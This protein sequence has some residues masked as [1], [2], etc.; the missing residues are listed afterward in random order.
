MVNE[1]DFAED[2][3]YEILTDLKDRRGFRQL[4]DELDEDIENEIIE[5]WKEKIINQIR[6]HKKDN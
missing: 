4:F 3:C 6:K 1:D 5:E 2:V